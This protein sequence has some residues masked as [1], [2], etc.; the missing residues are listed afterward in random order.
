MNF[1]EMKEAFLSY[2]GC[3]DQVDNAELALW[4]NEAQLDLA[5]E[6]GPVR[7]AVVDVGPGGSYTPGDDWLTVIGGSKAYRVSPD[8]NVLPEEDGELTL[9]YRAIP[10]EFNGVDSDQE[11]VLH[12]GLHYLLPIFAAS[13]YWDKEAE[14]GDEES[15]Q[16]NRWLSYYYQGKNLAKSRLFGRNEPMDVWEIRG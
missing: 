5:W 1:A 4:F 8:G 10:T 13:R 15:A 11:C 14:G 7:T 3:T 6:L 16:A 9:Y 2:T 12:K